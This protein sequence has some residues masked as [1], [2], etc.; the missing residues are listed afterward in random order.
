M[1]SFSTTMGLHLLILFILCFSKYVL[2]FFLI[3][4]PLFPVF[5]HLFPHLFPFL[6]AHLRAVEL[7]LMSLFHLRTLLGVVVTVLLHLRRTLSAWTTEVTFSVRAFRSLQYVGIFFIQ[8][9]QFFCLFVVQLQGADHL[10]SPLFYAHLLPFRLLL[11]H[12][13]RCAEY[14]CRQ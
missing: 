9:L 7:S 4:L 8:F 3:F 10:F 2:E 13:Q 12:A 6:L 5:S 11:C 1:P 14:G